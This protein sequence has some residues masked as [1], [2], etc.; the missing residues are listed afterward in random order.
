MYV[1]ERD[2]KFA[3]LTHNHPAIDEVAT[4]FA[5]KFRR[6]H[7]ESLIRKIIDVRTLFFNVR[8]FLYF[9]IGLVQSVFIVRKY[10]PS[11]VFL[12][13][14][15]VGVPVGVAAGLQKR[16]IVTHDSDTMAGL[17][18]RLVD[19]WTTVHATGG[20]VHLYPYAKSKVVE[21]G[22]LVE[23]AYVKVDEAL[24]CDYKQQLGIDTDHELLLI[25]GGS[26]GAQRLNEATKKILEGLF[27]KYP[28]LTV[29]HQV[30]KGKS[31]LYDGYSHPR[32]K[33]MEFL[34]PMHVYTGA[35]DI[36]VA[37]ASA[38]TVAE[39][40]SQHKAL[41]A[42]A[43]PVLAGGHQLKNAHVLKEQGA[44]LTVP[45]TR[46]AT[47]E[48]ALYEAVCVLLD[49]KKLRRKLAEQLHAQTATD[50]ASKLA[51]IIFR[52]KK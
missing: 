50:A 15:F 45:E 23:P 20:P 12:K 39:L 40:G 14:G 38:N 31:G 7:G 18:N 37:R 1:G 36:V 21:V 44:A 46:D 8:D 19:R 3:E 35:S 24:Q 32:L 25:T 28:N 51:D 11:V 17:A 13:G 49:D 9:L 4:I 48:T 43:S 30:G 27:K 16:P 34:R 52:I 26:S 29:V 42:V 41:I 10:K 33:V 47:N 22:V 2:G 6:Y 5:G